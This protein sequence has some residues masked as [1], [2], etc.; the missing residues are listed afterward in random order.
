MSMTVLG[1]PADHLLDETSTSTDV[2]LGL[3]L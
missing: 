1:L 3:L 2:Y